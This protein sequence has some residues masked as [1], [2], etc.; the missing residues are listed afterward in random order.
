MLDFQRYQLAF[1]A[2]IRNPKLHPKPANVVEKRMAIYRKAVQYNIFESVSACF[3]VC[4]KV[5]G[6]QAWRKLL[7]EF[8]AH[9]AA[10]TP[11]FREIAQQFLA[12]IKQKNDLPVY[13][14]Q[15]AHYEWVELSVNSQMIQ[16]PIISKS[17]DLINEIPVIATAHS[18]MEY[19]YPV[20]KISQRFKPRIV[21]KIYLL[22]FRNN[23]LEVKFIELNP[24][25][26]QLLYLIESNGLTGEQALMQLAIDLENM[27]AA[28][29]LK[30]GIAILTDLAEQEAIIGSTIIG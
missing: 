2:H 12:F 7:S 11:I 18:L 21:E 30:Y 23:A 5:I 29:I 26:Y 24:L 1:T 28:T 14:K 17:V 6:L 10:E 13:L 25:T 16:M 19:D 8:V 3:P 20:H 4:Q 15:L 27:D 22:V 9:Y